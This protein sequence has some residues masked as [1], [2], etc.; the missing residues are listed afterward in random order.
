MASL[1]TVQARGQVLPREAL[2]ALII[3]PLHN[4]ASPSIGCDGRMDN[5][6]KFKVGRIMGVQNYD[7][8]IVTCLLCLGRL[9]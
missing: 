7:D 4:S 5:R 8:V 1:C 9:S 3:L 2:P 6:W